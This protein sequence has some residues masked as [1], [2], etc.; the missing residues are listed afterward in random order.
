MSSF[1]STFATIVCCM[2]SVT[3]ESNPTNMCLNCLRNSIDIT[4]GI[5]RQLIIYSCRT[6]KRF[7][8]PP[9]QKL[10]LESKE[11]MSMCLRK[12]PG[13]KKVKLIDAVWIWTESH[14]LRLQMKLTI[15]KEIMNNAVLQQ[16][17]VVDFLIRNQ[18]CKDCE[19]SFTDAGWHA[20]VQLRQRVSHKRTFF[21]IEQLLL[22]YNAHSNALNIITFKDG[23]DFY[24][25]EKQQGLRFIDFLHSHIPIK[26]KY[27]RKLVSADHKSNMANFKNNFIVE[28]VPICKDDLIILPKKLAQNL[29]DI[30]SLC[31]IK[32]IGAGIHIIDPLTGEV[33]FIFLYQS[34]IYYIILY[35]YI[36]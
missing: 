17:V 34:M 21:Y 29:S 35:I 2:C 25:M 11:L 36:A 15:Q 13:L 20:V 10:E 8:C 26:T 24:F 18:Q 3:M 27:S 19:I 7:L 32:G 6:C 12:I 30:S 28:I 23:M 31:L 33:S 16:A 9:W 5:T 1:T 22:K 4:D 14:S